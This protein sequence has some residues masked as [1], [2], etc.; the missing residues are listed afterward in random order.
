MFEIVV[1]AA[2]DE[3]FCSVPGFPLDPLAA[4]RLTPEALLLAADNGQPAGRCSLWWQRTPALGQERVGCVGHFAVADPRAANLLLNSACARLAEQGCTLAIGPLDGN[5]WQRYRLVTERGDEPPFFLE[6]D[7]PDT[8]PGLFA[9]AGFAP[10]AHYYSALN[11][12]LAAPDARLPVLAQR[13][14]DAGFVFRSLDVER[15]EEELRRVHALSL[16]AF[17]DNFL[18]TPISA[19]DFLAQYSGIRR[20]VRPDLSLLAERDGQLAGYLFALPDLLRGQRGEPMNTVIVKT[21]AVHPDHAGQGLGTLLMARAQ[22]AAR[23]A[24]FTRA[25]HALF[26]ESNRSGK[27]SGHTARVFRRYTLFARALG[28]GR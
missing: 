28:A 15:F 14:H 10:L 16:V 3:R 13:L 27:I 21:M 6:P 9:E 20:F 26:H 5:T 8:W 1:L 11:T 23:Q 17:R 25:I 7:N 2:A 24:G 12:T 22:E 18:Y 4:T 19:E